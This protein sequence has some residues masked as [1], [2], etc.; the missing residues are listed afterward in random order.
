MDGHALSAICA[1]KAAGNFGAV[2][3]NLPDPENHPNP[4][5]E[6][7]RNPEYMID[8]PLS[9]I[10]QA[11]CVDIRSFLFNT[12]LEAIVGSGPFVNIETEKYCLIVPDNLMPIVGQP[13][14]KMQ[15]FFHLN[16]S[17]LT[18]IY[19]TDTGTFCM[20]ESEFKAK[21]PN[22]KAWHI[23]FTGYRVPQK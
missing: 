1:A 9:P 16:G 8:T 2:Y 4:V 11:V 19:N 5:F 6:F 18:V 22:K 12:N 10:E 15:E 17:Q 14:T 23:P 3:V 20:T 13:G 21:Y 7:P